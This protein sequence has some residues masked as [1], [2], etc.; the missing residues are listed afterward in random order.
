MPCNPLITD[1]FVFPRRADNRAGLPRIAYRIGRYAD[2][3]EDTRKLCAAAAGYGPGK[4]DGPVR[5]LVISYE[6]EA[7]TS[8]A[9]SSLMVT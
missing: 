1:P 8:E 9:F 6:R 4:W 3:V 7:R 5:R 2:F